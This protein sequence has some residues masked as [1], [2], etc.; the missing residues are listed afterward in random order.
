MADAM[1]SH[2]IIASGVIF[3]HFAVFIDLG[4]FSLWR[5]VF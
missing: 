1:T 4:L 3:K 2:Y 5:W